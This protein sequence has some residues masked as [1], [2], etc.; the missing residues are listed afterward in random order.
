MLATKVGFPSGE[1]VNRRGA[2]PT[3]VRASVE[4]SLTRLGT[5]RIDLYYLHRFDRRTDIDHTLRTLDALVTSGKILHVGVSNFAAWQV[6]TALGRCALNGWAPIVALQ[7]MYN[8][9]KRQAEVELLPL[10]QSA[11][12]AVFPYSPLAGGLLTG[13]YGTTPGSG[14]GR[15]VT[16]KMYSIRYRDEGGFVAASELA[17]LAAEVGCHPATL[18]VAW[19][20][21]HPGVTA[22]LIGG[23]SLEQLRPSLAAVDF[24]LDDE[25]RD[26]ISALTPAPPPATDRSEESAGD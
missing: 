16:D 22:P 8:L 4:H 24:E 15:L 10:A 13:K 26:R 3:H 21:S 5:D 12:L 1:G 17:G 25:L 11:D 19:V 6:A 23:R 18:A 2:S 9:I 14:E 7:P 20:G